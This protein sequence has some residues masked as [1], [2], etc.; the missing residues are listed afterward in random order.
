MEALPIYDW[1]L[2]PVLPE[3]RTRISRADQSSVASVEPLVSYFTVWGTRDASVEKSRGAATRALDSELLWQT[4]VVL[5]VDTDGRERTFLDTESGSRYRLCG[6]LRGAHMLAAGWPAATVRAF[7]KVNNGRGTAFPT[8]WRRVLGEGY[9]LWRNRREEL[10]LKRVKT[11]GTSPASTEIRPRC[12]LLVVDKSEASPPKVSSRAQRAKAKKGDSDALVSQVPPNASREVRRLLEQLVRVRFHH[13]D[14]ILGASNSWNS[15]NAWQAAQTVV[16][17]EVVALP[18][19]SPTRRKRGRPRKQP[20]ASG[21]D[22]KDIPGSKAA[23]EKA[24]SSDLPTKSV[25][26]VRYATS[27]RAAGADD[28]MPKTAPDGSEDGTKNEAG[29][30]VQAEIRQRRRGEQPAS[31]DKTTKEE[32]AAK[33]VP[34]SS[35]AAAPRRRG[36]PRKHTT[37][38]ADSSKRAS[39][40]Q[41]QKQT[42]REE[43][44]AETFLASSRHRENVS[45]AGVSIEE[46]TVA[47]TEADEESDRST[48][49]KTKNSKRVHFECPQQLS[50]SLDGELPAPACHTQRRA[51]SNTLEKALATLRDSRSGQTEML[52]SKQRAALRVV[53]ETAT[54]LYRGD[55]I[56]VNDENDPVLLDTERS[57]SRQAPN[58][59]RT[60]RRRAETWIQTGSRVSNDAYLTQLQRRRTAA[61]AN[62]AKSVSSQ[63]LPAAANPSRSRASA[64]LDQWMQR[65]KE[66]GSATKETTWEH[67]TDP[68]DEFE[69]S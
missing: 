23:S 33:V 39:T 58:T 38:S 25:R 45:Y 57:I 13:P 30:M 47:S 10:D 40:P 42:D 35:T 2:E 51:P 59:F 66:N 37:T 20:S 1:F 48:K 6:S 7:Q 3:D 64:T 60:R 29:L 5:R 19:R 27:R 67:E 56:F 54:K 9:R 32:T 63:P 31:Q 43:S 28:S 12:P 8:D 50:S 34:A 44:S 49:G 11:A 46:N 14:I 62:K 36:R 41:P 65:A 18:P 17:A 53:S 15:S 69:S 22:N 52:S 21:S 24:A 26:Q 68:E 16:G 61:L 55:S 4:S